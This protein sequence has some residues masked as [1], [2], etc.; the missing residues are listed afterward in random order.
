MSLPANVF[1]GLLRTLADQLIEQKLDHAE[2]IADGFGTRINPNA[3]R[4]FS[5]VVQEE[6]LPGDLAAMGALVDNEASDFNETKFTFFIHIDSTKKQKKITDDV[7]TIFKKMVLSHE[8]CHFVFYYELFMNFGADLTDTLY[9]QFQST[10]SGK[11]KNAITKEL[12]VTSETVT[13]E[14]I[15]EEFFRNFREYPNSHFDKKRLTSH[16]YVESNTLFF[17]FL[18]KK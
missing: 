18:T 17:R 8:T 14:H 13:D 3:K 9:T 16:D 2:C 4:F 11:L 12:D 7:K 10:V 6:D 5:I 1:T 15:Y